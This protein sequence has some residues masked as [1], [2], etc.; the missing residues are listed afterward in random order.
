MDTDQF[1]LEDLCRTV[2][3]PAAEVKK[4][5]EDLARQGV[6][7]LE[8]HLVRV[9]VEKRL[10]IAVMA[11]HEGA[12]LER[13]CRLLSWQEFEEIAV[14][15]LQ[16][17]GYSVFKHYV[18]KSNDHRR[19]IDV[20]GVGQTLVVCLDCKHW[21]KGIRGTVGE[22][23]ATRQIERVQGLVGN[24]E[25][26]SRL[27]ISTRRTLYFVPAIVSLFDT[28]PRFI[29]QVPIVPVLKLNSFLSSLDPFVEGLFTVQMKGRSEP[30]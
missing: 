23:V 16:G 10:S 28:G 21:M 24:A 14:R 22:K 26:R 6:L 19:E 17:N 11:L 20:I 7:A 18:F 15:S 27:G 25:S 1:V 8:Q 4:C 3:M 13:V 29:S 2:R 30:N 5:V 9:G 12:D